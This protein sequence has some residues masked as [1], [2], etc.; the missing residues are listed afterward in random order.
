MSKVLLKLYLL[1]Q[2]LKNREDGQDLV[3]YA[4]VASLISLAAIVAVKSMATSVGAAFT[5]IGTK[6]GSYIS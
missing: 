6:L 5:H 4:V 3:E 1:L 2:D